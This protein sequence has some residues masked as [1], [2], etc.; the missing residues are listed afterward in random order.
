MRLRDLEKAW[1]YRRYVSNPLEAARARRMSPPG[2]LVPLRLRRGGVMYVRSGTSDIHVFKDVFLRDSYEVGSLRRLSHIGSKLDC[3]VDIGGHIGVFSACVSPLATKVVACEP[4]A[5]NGELFRRNMEAAG[6]TNV[7]L[8]EA[9]V[10]A[11]RQEIDLYVSANDAG[12]SSLPSLSDT[13]AEARRVPA[14]SLEELFRVHNIDRCDLLKIDCEGGEYDILYHT[15][16]E[17]FGR[18]ARIALE[19]HEATADDPRFTSVALARYL[20][21]AGYRVKRRVPRRRVGY[22]LLVARR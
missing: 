12:H 18:I 7:T 2:T 20:T 8:V 3:V 6:C 5:E 14:I 10:S 11:T 21:D 22:G 1:R 4:I 17:L 19:F 16:P 13:V 15:S 9:A